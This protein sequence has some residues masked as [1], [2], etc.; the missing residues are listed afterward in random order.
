KKVCI[1]GWSYGGYAALAGVTLTPELYKCGIAVAGVSDLIMMLGV[2]PNRGMVLDPTTAYWPKLIG[3]PTRDVE[4]L[5]AT[6]PAMH[7]NRAT[8]PLL[9]IHGKNDT[10][11]PIGQSEERAAAMAKARKPVEFV[12]VEGDD[13]H[14]YRA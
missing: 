8:A 13:H 3:D 10:I 6:S 4:R 12:R 11:V 7:A 14:M 5:R 2:E 9:L 1:V